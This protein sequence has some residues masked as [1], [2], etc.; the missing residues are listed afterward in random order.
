MLAWIISSIFHINVML[1]LR[2]RRLKSIILMFIFRAQLRHNWE[3]CSWATPTLLRS[4]RASQCEMHRCTNSADMAKNISSM[5]GLWKGHKTHDDRGTETVP[6]KTEVIQAV[7]FTRCLLVRR[8]YTHW[9]LE[10]RS[11]PQVCKWKW[12]KTSKRWRMEKESNRL[13]IYSGW[14]PV[15]TWQAQKLKLLN[16]M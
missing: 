9:P 2:W 6:L 7:I 12:N 16:K 4:H 1:L 11:D 15:I 14:F 5:Y 8:W 13:D 3:R 10:G